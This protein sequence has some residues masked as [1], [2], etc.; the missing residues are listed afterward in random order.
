M[1]KTHRRSKLDQSFGCFDGY[2]ERRAYGSDFCIGL[3]EED[4]ETA[5]RQARSTAWDKLYWA[6]RT[7]DGRS[8]D[9]HHYS[10]GSGACGLFRYLSKKMVRN[11]TKRALVRA[12][13]RG[14]WDDAVY[15]TDRDGK[16]F[17]WSVW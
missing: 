10:G 5:R 6:R 17:I 11:D 14:D 1:G 3:I 9:Y 8:A 4:V 7:R 16:K 15:P 12:A 13:D 2:I